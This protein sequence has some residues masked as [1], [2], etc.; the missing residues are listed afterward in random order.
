M[1]NIQPVQKLPFKLYPL[2]KSASGVY[3]SENGSPYITFQFAENN[4]RVLR[5][6]SMFLCGRLRVYNKNKLNCPANR[7]DLAGSAQADTES[8]EEVCYMDDR[9]GCNSVIDQF[10]IQDLR[11]SVYEQAPQYNRHMSA[12][13]GATN[14]YKHLCSFSNLHYT[15]CVNNDV[16]AREV[17]SDMEFS[18]P[19]MCGYFLSNPN[20]PMVR[21]LEIK[22]RLA[23]AISALFGKDAQNYTF[24]LHDVYLMGDHLG[25]AKPIK[26]APM[27]YVSTRDFTV[28]L[29]SGNDKS[30][31]N[32][33]LSMVNKMTQ[34]FLPAAWEQS[35]T[36]S[37]YSTC[38]ML[39]FDGNDYVEAR[40]KRYDI[41]RN[42]QKFPLTYAVDETNANRNNVFQTIK[43]R[44]YLNSI[45]PYDKI[46]SSLISP[47]SENRTEMVMARTNWLKT[48][49]STDQGLTPAWVKDNG[50]GAW[51][52]TGSVEKAAN[53]TGIGT[54]YDQLFVR[55]FTDFSNA[56]FSWSIQSEL[57]NTTNNC[58]VFCTAVTKL[59]GAGSKG[60]IVAL[61]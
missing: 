41:N 4:M 22:L 6:D 47:D 59:Q 51:T 10:D 19:L 58:I 29:N 33:S 5:S 38:P 9:V 15:A 45:V 53:C 35:Y 55:S 36:H 8:W 42:E 18:L 24:A 13:I 37:S 11:G 12:I 46:T 44:E 3:T 40:I 49:Q 27:S 39:N 43:S 52:R 2:N 26:D 17:C 32:L 60:Q 25:L 23:S 14:S 54:N 50:T 16:Q 21:G 48:P 57:D 31:L 7:F 28:P 61:T 34:V 20:I 56:N 1:N 30:V